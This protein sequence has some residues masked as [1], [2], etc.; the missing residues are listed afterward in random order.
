[1]NN[2]T[3]QAKEKALVDFRKLSALYKYKECIH[4]GN[5]ITSIDMN[6]TDG[7]LSIRI[8]EIYNTKFVFILIAG[9]VINCYELQ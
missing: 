1:M 8:M 2:T 9:E 5:T 6:T 4:Y 7:Y 3:Q